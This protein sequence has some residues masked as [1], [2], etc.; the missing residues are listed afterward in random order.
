MREGKLFYFNM[1]AERRKQPKEQR[2][3]RVSVFLL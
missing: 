1:I 2:F 3:G